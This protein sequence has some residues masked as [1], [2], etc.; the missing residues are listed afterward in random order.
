MI[1]VLLTYVRSTKGLCRYEEIVTEG[2]RPLLGAIYLAKERLGAKPP[3]QVTL[4]V[5]TGGVVDAAS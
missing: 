1:D 4:S 2:Q 5:T 3:K